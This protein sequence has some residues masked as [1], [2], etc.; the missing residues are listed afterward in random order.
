MW[1][2]A[3]HKDQALA[4]RA[5]AALVLIVILA[6]MNGCGGQAVRDDPKEITQVVTIPD[7][8]VLGYI[9]ADAA[10]AA[11][12]VELAEGLLNQRDRVPGLTLLFRSLPWD[13]IF[14]A[15]PLAAPGSE[16]ILVFLD[17]G[18][19]GGGGALAF[20]PSEKGGL[21]RLLDADPDYARTGDDPPQF[22]MIRQSDMSREIFLAL[23][24]LSALGFDLDLP[25]QDLP[26]AC[27]I[28]EDERG[29]LILPSYDSRR[30][31]RAFLESTDYLSPWGDAGLVVHLDMRRLAVAYADTLRSLESSVRKIAAKL[32]ATR[33]VDH[34]I[35]PGRVLRFG[36]ATLLGFLGGIEGVRF[37]SV[38]PDSGEAELRILARE[39]KS[40]H[41]FLGVLGEHGPA[42]TGLVP[43]G[44][45]AQIHIDPS[46]TVGLLQ[47][48]NAFYTS[49]LDLEPGTLDECTVALRRCVNLDDGG[50]L[51][52]LGIG[53]NGL[54][55]GLFSRM[56]DEDLHE[57]IDSARWRAAAAVAA[58]VGG[59]LDPRER[60][61]AVNAERLIRRFEL[62]GGDYRLE[63]GVGGGFHV[64]VLE[65]I[66][67]EDSADRR[68]HALIS[69]LVRL[70]DIGVP[71]TRRLPSKAHI[72][73]K[74]SLVP[75]SQGATGVLGSL[76][77]GDVNGVGRVE[78]RELVLRCPWR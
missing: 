65:P 75:F 6:P 66:P 25:A 45:A 37:V 78:G 44:W 43:G 60:P 47:E 77:V 33:P 52:G 4:G 29:V 56:R 51:L 1:S 3:D 15:L 35:T 14:K 50:Y 7:P 30:D 36:C 54:W 21:V 10:A 76:I 16:M 22:R 18:T 46:Q 41:R 23:D 74:F 63:T 49:V 42:K 34:P 9:R 12:V 64:A 53:E 20:Q 55:G 70:A 8:S 58:L 57:L 17:P 69:Q 38:A 5:L 71:R 28:E 31:V 72:Y 67:A 62:Q 39:G 48:L 61:G 73:L 68:R 26:L 32:D 40:L 19:F 24:A 13:M 11:G 59:E 2:G 27:V